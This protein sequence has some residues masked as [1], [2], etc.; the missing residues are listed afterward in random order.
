MKKLLTFLILILPVTVFA[1]TAIPWIQKNA[2]DPFFYPNLTNGSNLRVLIGQTSEPTGSTFNDLMDVA[3]SSANDFDAIGIWNTNSGTCASAEYDANNN[4]S[5]LSTNY[6][7]FGITG[8]NF[9]GSGCANNP[10]PAFGANSAYSIV[11]NGNYNWALG[12]TSSAAQFRWLTDTNGDSQ[13]TSADTK[14]ILTQAGYLGV[15]S[16]TPDSP[17]T[18]SNNLTSFATPQAGT[19]LHVAGS[20]INSRITVDTY[21][22]GVTGAIFQGR[23]AAGTNLA[24]LPPSLDQTLG[25][26]AGDGY[27]TSGFHNVSLGGFFVK[28]ESTPFTNT[29]AATYLG[30]YTTATTTI[31][32]SEK[33]RITSTGSVGIGTSSPVSKLTIIQTTT[34]NAAPGVTIDGATNTANADMVL[35]RANNSGTESNIDFNTAGV[36][37][38]QLGLQNNSSN[39]FELWDGSDNSIFVINHTTLNAGFGTT[40]P[41]SLFSIGGN[42]TGWNFFN[43]ATTTSAAKGI[44]LINGGC[45][46]ISGVCIST[47]AS[48]FSYDAW[49]HPLLGLS[50]TT[51]QM[52]FG[53]STAGNFGVT[54][55]TSTAPQLSLS[56]GTGIPQWTFRNAGGNLYIGPTNTTGTATTTPNITI[57]SAGVVG[58]NTANPAAG[59]GLDITGI[60]QIGSRIDWR[61]FGTF[62]S[63]TGGINFDCNGCTPG[64]NLNGQTGAGSSGNISIGGVG[65]T[66]VMNFRTN[67]TTVRMVI[68]GPGNVGI[69]TT[70]PYTISNIE[71]ASS[72]A[73]T[74]Q[75]TPF[76]QLISGTIA[77]VW[78][79]LQS[80]DY[81]GHL[82]TS[83]PA[84]TLSGCGTSPSFVGSAND[85]NMVVQVGSVAAT[86]CTITFA[87]PYTTAPRVHVTNRS[88]SVVNAMTY[89]VSTTQIVV[90]QT[91][92]TSAILDISAEGTR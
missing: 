28:A 29:S 12:S 25:G 74:V 84:P 3:S 67:A 42:G 13:F 27:G 83:G 30:F 39:D 52:L 26:F 88:M 18:I 16:T 49:T 70:T 45:F 31:S 54:I 51:S 48:T 77:G 4:A 90:S 38:F 91:G 78:Y 80:F 21:N 75:S 43:N 19:E 33:M 63:L 72:T 14:M 87:Y 36:N 66:N 89:T 50:A 34:G 92:L 58:I 24:P 81:Y 61:A 2:T 62:M 35:N 15:G 40:T 1:T 53:T 20:G 8:G 7:S 10:F 32:S 82:Y 56:A 37:E 9:T 57:N 46:A 65:T 59:Y 22:A 60:I 76:S 73:G 11:T 41:G 69:G 55:S 86:G 71:T 6:A 17:V 85:R 44:N 68:T 47:G 79:M 64:V 5:T 23:S